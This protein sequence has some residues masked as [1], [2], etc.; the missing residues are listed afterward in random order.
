MKFTTHF[1]LTIEQPALDFVD[2]N[3]EKD[4]PL[5]IDPYVFSSQDDDWSVQC[6][7]DVVSFFQTAIE[8]IRAG[9]EERAKRLLSSLNEPNETCLGISRKEP[10]GRG[11]S[12]SQ[13][14]DLYDQLKESQAVKA[15]VLSELSDCELMVEGIGRDKISDITTNIIRRRLVEYTQEQCRIHN[16]PMQEV[17]S[18]RLWNSETGNWEQGYS[19]LPV[20][21][22]KKIILVPKASVRRSI[23]FSHSEYY[24]HFVLN[25]LQE[26][27]LTKVHSPLV[28]VLKKGKKRIVTKKSLKAKY[29]L[30]KDFLFTF[31]QE[32]PAVLQRYKEVKKSS[33]PLSN[34]D[35]D[36][37][38][39]ED[40][41][42][43]QIAAELRQIPTG[44]E[45]AAE[46]HRLMI[47]TLEFILYPDLIYP[48][49]EDAIHEGRK[50]IDITYSNSATAGLFYRLRT[51]PQFA[52][53]KVIVECKN[54]EH[55]PQNPALDQLTGR[56]G[57]TRGKFGMLL[58]RK[59]EDRELFLSRCRDTAKDGRGF[60]IPLADVDIFA[61][62]EM[63][64]NN[65]RNEID[66]YLTA[67]LD[68]V[69]R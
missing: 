27:E 34:H 35:L 59:F 40:E 13:A 37:N 65:R 1:G 24:N 18:G 23:A 67:I 15:G 30:S 55:D 26:E 10:A 42:A 12:G 54:Y 50:R 28:R 5:Y 43:E 32:Y 49:K 25:F 44:T 22:G 53:V 8:C 20:V 33:P 4:L 56:F 51:S 61:L 31:S 29:P 62:L 46:Y 2:V 38:F 52:A 57:H 48:E 7:N 64:S 47:G 14:L 69:L 58:A 45:Y 16:I 19:Q 39:Y 41:F 6:H 68:E 9:E 11:V 3:P 63:V 36:E 60:V 66:R 21:N 17:T